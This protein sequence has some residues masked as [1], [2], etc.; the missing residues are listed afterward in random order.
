ML[1]IY[2][3]EERRLSLQVVRC[4]ASQFFDLRV[5]GAVCNLATELR[6]GATFLG[7]ECSHDD[8]SELVEVTVP[9]LSPKA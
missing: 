3:W 5:V 1:C 6:L 4:F 7:V 8:V 2:R 9:S